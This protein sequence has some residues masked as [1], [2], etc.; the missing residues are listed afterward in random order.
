MKELWSKQYLDHISF[1]TYPFGLFLGS[2]ESPRVS[3]GIPVTIPTYGDNNNVDNATTYNDQRRGRRS[4]GINSDDLGDM[5]TL[6]DLED[7]KT[8]FPDPSPARLSADSTG[9]PPVLE[10]GSK[11][12]GGRLLIQGICEAGEVL[13]HGRDVHPAWVN[14]VTAALALKSFG[15]QVTRA[16]IMLR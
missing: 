16:E 13:R 10:D 8:Y 7:A 1:I 14:V 4:P 12:L 6:R 3:A 15:G 2:F 5:T 11:R 9:R